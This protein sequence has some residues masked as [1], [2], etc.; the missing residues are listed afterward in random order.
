MTQKN[1]YSDS[2]MMMLING[3]PSACLTQRTLG[4]AQPALRSEL[5]NLSD[6]I[7]SF[8]SI[9]EELKSE[10][11]TPSLTAE[12]NIQE[13]KYTIPEKRNNITMLA[14]ICVVVL[15]FVACSNG[16]TNT[17]TAVATTTTAAATTTTAS[18][19]TTTA[20]ATTTTA[21]PT[22]TTAAATTTTAAPTTTTAAATTTTAA[23]TTATTAAPTTTT[24]A[25]TTS[26]AAAAN[27]TTTATSSAFFNDVSLISVTLA[28]MTHFIHSYC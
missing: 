20:A 4:W 21:A 27:T 8:L 9:K 15:L 19:T 10:N 28:L 12:D 14:K 23:P 26:T 16:Q 17:T 11:L 2:I 3:R 6:V 5:D 22:T 13:K 7:S 18:P 1:R 24:A 25:A